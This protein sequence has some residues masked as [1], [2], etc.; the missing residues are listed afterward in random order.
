ML[1]NGKKYIMSQSIKICHLTSAHPDGDIRIF[2]KE[3][4]SLAKERF[5]TYLVIPNTTTRIEKGVN[6]ISFESNFSSRRERMT[7]TVSQIYKK[8]LEIDADIYHFHDPELLRIAKKLI[9]KNKKVIYDVHEDLPK[10]IL[11]KYWINKSLRKSMSKAFKLYENAIAKKLTGIIT[12]TP[13]IAERFKKINSN[14]ITI[15]NFPFMDEL[16]DSHSE[17]LKSNNY[18]C[19]VGGISKI[20]GVNEL[21]QA[22]GLCNNVKLLLAGP[23][24]PDSYFDE[25][26]QLNGWGNVEYL[27][28][29]SREEVAKVLNKSSAGLVTFHPLPN[30]VD[31]QPNKMFEYMSAG[32]PVIGSH[33]PLWKNIIEENNC[34]LCINPLSPKEIA[35]AI[36]KI[37]IDKKIAK[38]MGENGRKSVINEFNWNVEESKLIRFYKKL[39]V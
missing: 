25:L 27:G 16:N 26:K 6:I 14:T 5:K 36:N 35:I 21:V 32:L 8:A 11:G 15:N 13:F 39:T 29:I 17:S 1:Q 18:V 22:I 24:S 7:K 10:Q 34:G 30:H 20:R 9:R 33:F 31:A 28:K 23:I 2:H 12:A 37:V 19:Y 38:Q 4:V 3:C